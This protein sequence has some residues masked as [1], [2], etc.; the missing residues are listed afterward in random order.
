MGFFSWDCK[1]CGHPLLSAMAATEDNEWM[2]EGVA[3]LHNG[4]ILHG[5]YD[6]YGRLNDHEVDFIVEPECW[7]RS[8]WI[9]AGKPKW[10]SA[11][12]GAEDQGWFFEDGVHNMPDPLKIVGEF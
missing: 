3:L 5:E 10:T 12:E 2:T 1:G 6:G 9:K 11:S 7:H 8:C 4:T